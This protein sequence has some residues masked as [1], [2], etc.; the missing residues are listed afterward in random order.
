MRD[1][2]GV[3]RSLAESWR[4]H[5]GT[6]MILRRC[7]AEYRPARETR[8]RPDCPVQL[9][10]RRDRKFWAGCR[11]TGATIPRS[12]ASMGLAARKLVTALLGT[13]SARRPATMVLMPMTRP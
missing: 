12:Q 10:A 4:D 1:A 7:R 13:A 9:P 3:G 5:R 11:R 8:L 6:R 2:E